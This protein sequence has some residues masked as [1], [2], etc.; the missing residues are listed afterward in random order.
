MIED[1]ETLEGEMVEFD[2]EEVS[3]SSVDRQT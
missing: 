3:D 2:G 1:E